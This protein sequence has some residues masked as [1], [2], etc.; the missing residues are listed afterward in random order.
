MVKEDPGFA[1]DI[2]EIFTRRG[3]TASGCHGSGEGGLTMTSAGTAHSNLVNRSSTGAPSETLVIPGNA[4]GSYLMK[5]L[6]G[7]SGIV[8]VQMPNGGAPLDTIDMNNI[9][10][11]INQG[12]KNN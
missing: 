2:F 11:W 5:K 7:A 4:A 8:G 3:C 6:T 10:N 9:R 1:Q 12:A